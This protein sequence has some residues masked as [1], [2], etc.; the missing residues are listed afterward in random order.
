MSYPKEFCTTRQLSKAHHQQMMAIVADDELFRELKAKMREEKYI[1]NMAIASAFHASSLE[2]I[3]SEAEPTVLKK[4]TSSKSVKE[5]NNVGFFRN[6]PMEALR[7]LSEC[8]S[9]G[10]L[11][12]E[13]YK[14]ANGLLEKYLKRSSSMG[15]KFTQ[16]VSML[17]L[18][19]KSKTKRS[20][21]HQSHS[22]T[23]SN[24]RDSQA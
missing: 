10:N 20:L 2:I 22:I 3:L 13:S 12:A 19:T 23:K 16:K 21:N 24:C 9:Q 5:N 7:C 15:L 1:T 11:I 8:L 14:N 17:K 18:W 4:I 6:R